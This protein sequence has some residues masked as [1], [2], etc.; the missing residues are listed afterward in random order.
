MHCNTCQGPLVA[1]VYGGYIHDNDADD[2]HTPTV[3]A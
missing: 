2:T 3:A 1:S